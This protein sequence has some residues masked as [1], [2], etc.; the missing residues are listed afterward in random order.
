MDDPRIEAELM[1][2]KAHRQRVADF[3]D[4]HEIADDRRD[5]LILIVS[6]LVA[7]AMVHG[8]GLAE[9]HLKMDKR[10]VVVTVSQRDAVEPGR[11]G[12]REGAGMGL[13]LVNALAEQVTFIMIK[14]AV[15]RVIARF[16][17]DEV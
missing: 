4:E 3:A 10:M 8:G 9:W 6:E 16:R 17:A 13:L 1:Q 7:N 2:L 11:T 15:V 14:G 5:T 12:W